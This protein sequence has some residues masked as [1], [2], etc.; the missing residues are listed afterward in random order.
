MC[1]TACAPAWTGP[2][3]LAPRPDRR[4]I[5][6]YTGMVRWLKILLPVA[7]LLM[8]GAIF[9]VGRGLDE[10][11]SLLSPEEL[12]TLGAG[13]KLDSPR[14]SGRTAAGEAYVVRAEWALPDSAM[15]ETVELHRPEGEI[16]LA[17]GPRLTAAAKSGELTRS[18]KRLSLVGSVVIETSDGYRFDSERLVIDFD[19]ATARSPVPVT[20]EGPSGTIE[21]GAMRVRRGAEGAGEGRIFFERGVRVV[22]IPQAGRDGADAG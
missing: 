14:F 20:V 17:D 6:G 13:L 1:T 19:D 3:A 5:A 11:E 18:D 4:R 2:E 16:D 15:P 22:F 9:L 10:G 8:V 7:A 12:A 21:A